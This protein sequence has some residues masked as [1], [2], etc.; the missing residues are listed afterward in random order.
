[1]AQHL[2]TTVSIFRFCEVCEAR[3]FGTGEE[4]RPPISPICSGEQGHRRGRPNS[5]PPA[6][7]PVVRT[8]ELELA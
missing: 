6:A 7:P 1:M 2:W 3:Q 5:Y 8:R 4:W